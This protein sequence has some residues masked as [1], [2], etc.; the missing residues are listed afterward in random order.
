MSAGG[1]RAEGI[2]MRLKAG[3][4]VAVLLLIAACGGSGT[5]QDEPTKRATASPSQPTETADTLEEAVIEPGK[6]GPYVV[7]MSSGEAL[8]QGLIREPA[9]G[10]PCPAREA[11]EPF[12]DVA[13]V[14]NES[15]PRPTL[16]GVLVKVKG[17]ETAEGIGVGS[18]IADLKAAYGDQ[19]RLEDGDYGE[20]VFRIYERDL[21]MGFT[22]SRGTKPRMKI[23]AIEVFAK[24]DPVIWDGC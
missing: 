18:S 13:V 2:L 10:A 6:V 23:D 22:S 4:A 17:P 3:L 15:D 20:K 5:P 12:Q 21:A 19:L 7:G 14:F 16:L 9:E 8:D 1:I 24:S 11:T